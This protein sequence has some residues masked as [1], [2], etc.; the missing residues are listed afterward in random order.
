MARL[1]H[2]TVAGLVASAARRLKRAGVFFGHGTDNATDEAAALVLH[3]LDLPYDAPLSKRRVSAASR[4]RVEELLRRRIDERIPLA[5]LTRE[6]W[7]AGLPFFVDQRVLIPRSA[8]AE[9]VERRFAPWIDATRVKNVLDMGTGS[10]CIALACAK[11]FPRARVDAVDIDAGALEVAAIN[12]RRLRL[13]RRVRLIE[14]DHFTALS[15]SSYDI[16]V[17]NPPYVGARE[18]RSLPR[19]YGHEPRGALAS[20]RD[21]L[22]SV[23]T[24]LRDA[25]KFLRPRGL[26]VVEVGNTER[27]MARAFPDL[28]F[29]WLEFERGGGG[30]FLLTREQLEKAES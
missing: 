21:G 28:P 12:R 25:G 23:A 19:E 30:V 6:A 9:L 26:L 13:T 4:E 5:Y 8:I 2:I 20:G 3:A 10:G 14:S 17:S 24:I 11:A 7:F 1:F 16:I 18:M 29:T 27:L 15:G 22:E